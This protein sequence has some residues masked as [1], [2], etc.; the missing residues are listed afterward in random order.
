MNSGGDHIKGDRCAGVELVGAV[1]LLRIDDH[2][3]INAPEEASGR[4]ETLSFRKQRLAPCQR[5]AAVH[6]FDR[7]A[8]DMSEL[9]DQILVD[10]CR[11]SRVVK[12][13]CK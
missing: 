6:L 10:G 1:G 7:D 5:F 8:G 3:A 2:V 4:A 12:T 11:R 9:F 13:D